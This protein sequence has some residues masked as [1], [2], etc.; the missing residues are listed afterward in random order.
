MSYK[1]YILLW[2]ALGG[3]FF[4]QA[5]GVSCAPD[6]IAFTA[7]AAVGQASAERSFT[8]TA[9]SSG[10]SITIQP[11]SQ[12]EISQ[13]GKAYQRTPI[14]IA[15]GDAVAG[16]T[17]YV[18]FAPTCSGFSDSI[19]ISSVIFLNQRNELLGSIAVTGTVQQESATGGQPFKVATLNTEWLGCPE[20][21]P[22]NKSLQMKNM[23]S[24]IGGIGA[25][26]IAL[27]EVTSN[28]AKSLDTVLAHLGNEWGGYVVPHNPASCT[29]SEAIVY[30]KSRVTLAGTPLLMSN[31]GDHQAWSSGRYPVEF[32]LE[33]NISGSRYIPITL[34][35]LHAKAY[36]DLASY[37]RRAQAS[38]GL[39][40]LLD[41]TG[42]SSQNLI[43][44]G[45]YNDDIDVSTYSNAASPYK[46]FADDSLSYRF[47]TSPIS[48][49]QSL[50]DHIMISNELLRFY[51]PASVKRDTDVTSRIPDYEVTTSDH[52]PVSAAFAFGKQEQAM[53]V[54]DLYI[55]NRSDEQSFELPAYSTANLPLS[56]AIDS[57]AA[58]SLDR[59]MVTLF[60]TGMVRMAVW[61]P[62]NIALAPVAK[63]F[64]LQATDR[65]VAPTIVAHPAKQDVALRAAAVFSVQATGTKLRYQWKKD[66][67]NIAGATSFRYSI[68]RV[69]SAHAGYYSCAVGNDMGSVTSQ[70]AP[71]CIDATCPAVATATGKSVFLSHIKA[72][73]NP[74]HQTFFAENAA[75]SIAAVRV[76]SISGATVYEQKNVHAP[77][78]SIAAHGWRSGVYVATIISDRGEKVAKILVKK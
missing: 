3:N 14:T 31:A 7:S 20:N 23:A 44:L 64:Y 28:P 17:L 72:Y 22:S 1:P 49:T 77:A 41:S 60:D 2:A 58:A 48:A 26:V 55:V 30:R 27:Q 66:G 11:S 34:I 67:N 68:A 47:L 43:V 78:L 16:Q 52:T 24:V 32:K 50:I 62:G 61:Q 33:V 29:Q 76:C 10:G 46:N 39:K 5:Q 18:R 75:G 9:A 53:L 36:A 74:V 6:R 73:P 15:A 70:A 42:Y 45:D 35:N 37:E 56:Y 69:G 59:R 19:I 21:G 25:D 8:V 38:Q 54:A 51:I 4:A 65:N 13:T 40:A 57:G 63:F 12:V 71:L